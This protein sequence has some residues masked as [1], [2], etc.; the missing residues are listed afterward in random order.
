MKTGTL[1]YRFEAKGWDRF[2][3][4]SHTPQDGTLVKKC[5]PVGCP[6]NGTMGHCFV[7]DATTGK[8]FGLVYTASLAPVKTP[9]ARKVEG[10]S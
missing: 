2:D 4:G 10:A 7:C 3:R 1:I 5:Q 9:R 8:F 6:P